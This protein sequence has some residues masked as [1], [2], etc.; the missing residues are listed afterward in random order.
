MT[1][2]ED[3][4]RFMHTMVRVK[5]LDASVDFYTRLLGMHVLRRTDYPEGRFTLVF[6]GYGPE[7]SHAVVELTHN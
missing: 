7:I 6:V 2:S 1:M 4:Y 3:K 5:N